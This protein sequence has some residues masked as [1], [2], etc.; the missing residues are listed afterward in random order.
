M[1]RSG[2]DDDDEEEDNNQ[3]KKLYT[4]QEKLEIIG[5]VKNG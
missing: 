4:V 5:R 2:G 1:K 3:K